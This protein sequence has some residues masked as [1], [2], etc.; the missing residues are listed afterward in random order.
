MGAGS[1]CVIH[2]NDSFF[3]VVSQFVRITVPQTMRLLT[4][5]SFVLSATSCVA[6]AWLF[7]AESAALGLMGLAVAD[8][9]LLVAVLRLGE[10]HQAGGGGGV[11]RPLRADDD[12]E[13]SELI[14]QA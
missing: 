14:A 12:D 13:G 2:V 4:L 11:A 8:A 7:W 10:Q 9:V 5:G 1:N 6:T 3:W